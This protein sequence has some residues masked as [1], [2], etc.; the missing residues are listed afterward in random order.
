MKNLIE[1]Q[2]WAEGIRECLRKLEAWLSDQDSYMEKV[3]LE[4]IDELLTFDST[5]CNEPAYYKLKVLF[6][7]SK[8]VMIFLLIA[9]FYPLE[10]F[11]GKPI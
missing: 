8:T 4:F 7:L 1:A 3:H 5:P 6:M 2:K 11:G 9:T 10:A